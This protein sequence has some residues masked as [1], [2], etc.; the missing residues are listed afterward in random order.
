MG[1]TVESSTC[2]SRDVLVTIWE[3]DKMGLCSE[4]FIQ[5]AIG[6]PVSLRMYLGVLVWERSRYRC[7]VLTS[8]NDKQIET[9]HVLYAKGGD[10]KDE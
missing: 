9:R 5:E 4:P 2:T 6:P 1:P 8:R 7:S 3:Q 10:C